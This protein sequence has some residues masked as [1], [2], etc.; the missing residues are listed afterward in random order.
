MTV[1]TL[2]SVD[3]LW[4][5]IPTL[6]DGE[7]LDNFRR[8]G[9]FAVKDPIGAPTTG[10]YFL[11]A[12]DTNLGGQR[13]GHHTLHRTNDG[14][15]YTRERNASGWTSWATGGGGG[16]AVDGVAVA[17]AL[18]AYLGAYRWRTPDKIFN[19]LDYGAVRGDST[20]AQN[21]TAFEL[22]ILACE[23]A[24]GG[25]IYAPGGRY[26]I[27]YGGSASVGGVRL[28]SNMTLQGDGMGVTIIQCADIGNNDLAGVVRTQSGIENSNVVVRDLTIDGNKAAQTGWSNIICFYAGV[29][30]NDRVNM[31]RDIQCINVEVKN[32]KNGTAGSSNLSRGYGFDPHEVVDR[33]V[34]INCYAHDCE[35]DG[36]V[37][38]GVLNFQLIGNRSYNN[39]RYGFNIITE[40]FNGLITANIADGNGSNN[41]MVQGDSHHI[42]I[43]G[44]FSF[45]A[46]EQG[47]RVRRGATIVDTFVTI[48]NNHVELSNKNGINL[49]GSNFNTVQHNVIIDSSQ[50]THNTYMQFSADEDDGDTTIFTGANDNLI[51]HNRA[52]VRA[53]TVNKAKA[54][55]REDLSGAQPQRNVYV[56]NHSEGHVS[57][58]Y[59]TLSTT[60]RQIDST[61]AWFNVLD[62]GVKRDGTNQT[63]ALRALVDLVSSLGGGVVY[64]PAGE[65]AVSGTGTA[66]QG[67]VALPSNVTLLGDG[68]GKTIFKLLDQVDVTVT[69]IVR[70][71]S[72][73][74]NTNVAVIGL[75]I[76]GNKVA[77][78]GI[79]DHTG[80]YTGG[81]GDSDVLIA[82][83]EVKN[84]Q[85]G[86]G[87]L[88]HGLRFKDVGSRLKAINVYTH[89][90][91]RDGV[92]VDT[93]TK[94]TLGSVRSINN[95]RNGFDFT[96][97]S[98][99]DVDNCIGEG[100]LNNFVVENDAFNIRFHGGKCSGATNEGF[101]IR[102]GGTIS[103]T[104]VLVTGMDI[105]ENGRDGLKISGAADN[106]VIAN[107]FRNNGQTT[108]ATYSDVILNKD[109]VNTVPLADNNVISFNTMTALATNKTRNAVRETA[110]EASNT[111]VQMNTYR[112]Q[113]VTPAVELT[114]TGSYVRDVFNAI[115]Y[116]TGAGGTATQATNKGSGVTINKACGTVNVASAAL[117]AGASVSFTLTNNQIAATDVVYACWASGGTANAYRVDVTAIAAGSCSVTITN[118]T[119]G[120][121]SESGVINFVVIKAVAA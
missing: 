88:G 89:D 10:D 111:V 56:F 25:V 30:P 90:N 77:Q 6:T 86:T 14:S 74:A 66:S 115:G 29:T 54:G 15:T 69:G 57:G 92:N 114:G 117:A 113:T 31:D 2:R 17:E 61:P 1:D 109:T 27:N 34:A 11:I 94:V 32:G 44:N 68:M 108:N 13:R 21:R 43:D 22:A 83:V 120:S 95:G 107:V 51:Q 110:T 37:L 121:L 76:D 60:A 59:L 71:L 72:G 47:I 98:D 100:N 99:V 101:R 106:V 102:T 85:N 12:M 24:G 19:V 93:V 84:C 80:I 26:V 105:S 70:L 36:F 46:G 82:D 23:A 119:A 96:N 3:T 20:G 7:N 87:N 81:A 104:R 50:L 103:S 45:R 49:T 9:V 63:P 8:S 79:G 42:K 62:N 16:G 73:S 58:K 48:T 38:D 28:R 75:T 112:G 64:C 55:F 65:Y 118:T 78:T 33:F 97:C 18:D 41:Y 4:N 35:R 52:I 91:E 39:G 67:C 5:K 53:T 40:C 116:V